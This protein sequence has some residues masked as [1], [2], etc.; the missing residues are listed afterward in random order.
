LAAF[1]F[2]RG[3]YWWGNFVERKMD[4]AEHAVR[5]QMRNRKGTDMFANSARISTYN[6]LFGL[7]PASAYRQ[8]Q[9]PSKSKK[10]A[11]ITKAKAPHKH[12]EM[13]SG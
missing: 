1:Y 6:K 7:N 10:P 13:F 5:E 12:I 3:V 9:L 4:E 8:P 2:D 11:E